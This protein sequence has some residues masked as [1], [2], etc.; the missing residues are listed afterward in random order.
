MVYF[1]CYCF[2]RQ[3][4]VK[5]GQKEGRKKFTDLDGE[6]SD[7]L[8]EDIGPSHKPKVHVLLEHLNDKTSVLGKNPDQTVHPFSAPK[9][10]LPSFKDLALL[11]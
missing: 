10:L 11:A 5:K 7:D 4:V 8:Y 2:R 3:S 6:S 9:H 1:Y